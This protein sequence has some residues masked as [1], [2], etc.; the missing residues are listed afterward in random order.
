MNKDNPPFALALVTG[1]S[2]GIG[3]V[4]AGLL[5][6]KGINLI[7]HGRNKSKLESLADKLRS[8]VNVS[9]ITGD[10]AKESER[11]TVLETIYRQ[12]PDLVVNNA[13]MGLFGDALTYETEKELEILEVDGKAVI[14]LTM[15]AARTLISAQKKGVVMN[16]SSV[17]G[18]FPIA[19]GLALYSAV[20]AM[21]SHFSQS[22]DMETR[23]YGVRILASGPGLVN[24]N[25]R[26]RAG[27]D[28][29]DPYIA[30]SIVMTPEYAAEQIWKQIEKRKPL[31]IFDRKTKFLAA[32]SR[33]ILPKE[34]VGKIYHKQV[35]Q[36]TPNREIIKR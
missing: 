32:L 4:L 2:S 11:K 10:L 9:I 30:K 8:K 23:L 13:G 3:E 29:E 28:P 6:N 26:Q 22:F 36:R 20:K 7:I 34:W 17:A 19:P 15:E 1:A 31:H 27:G 18:E 12:V 25:F 24:T 14:Q 5:A 21:V 33:Y 16:I 35:T